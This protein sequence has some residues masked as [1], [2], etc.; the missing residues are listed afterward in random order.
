MAT[1]LRAISLAAFLAA[2]VSAAAPATAQ[3]SNLP[4]NYA[5]AIKCFVANGY[6][7]N[8]RRQAGDAAGADRYDRQARQSLESTSTFGTALGYD[9]RRVEADMNAAMDRELPLMTR[10]AAYM[11]QAVADC[12]AVGLM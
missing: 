8:L 12:R 3:Q 6:A 11:R 5:L 10:D 9:R 7:R 4:R 2:T 1:R